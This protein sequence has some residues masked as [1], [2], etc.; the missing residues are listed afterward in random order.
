MSSYKYCYCSA[1]K[2]KPEGYSLELQRTIRNHERADAKR[3]IENPLADGD[4]GG[5]EIDED[6]TVTN[7]VQEEDFEDLFEQHNCHPHDHGHEHA[8]YDPADFS[9]GSDS[10]SDIDHIPQFEEPEFSGSDEEPRSEA[11]G[12]DADLDLLEDPLF[13]A[14]GSI[15]SGDD[16]EDEDDHDELNN[17]YLPPAFQEHPAIR[18]TYIRAFLLA[19]LKGFTHNAVKMHLEGVALALRSAE[20]QSLA[21]HFEGLSTMACTLTTAEWRLGIY[22][23]HFITYF[24]LCDACWN[25]HHPSD[26]SKLLTPAC[27]EDGCTGTLYT[28]KWLSNGSEK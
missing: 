16:S 27:D 14:W 5:I 10:D 28:F 23:D 3:P 18:N 7:P 21:V 24:F 6:A 9:L 11:G 2:L 20:S 25:L 1:C 12:D 17:D 19:A 15:F 8:P 4:E 13:R 26:L 22:T